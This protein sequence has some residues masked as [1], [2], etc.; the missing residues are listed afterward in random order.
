M[1]TCERCHRKFSSYDALL[2]HYKGKH[3]NVTKLTQ[4]ENQVA[5]EKQT[6]V[7]YQSTIR[8]HGPSRVKLVAFVMIVIIAIGVVGYV[9][10]S[11]KEQ[12]GKKYSVGAVA[13]DF[14][15][16]DTAGGTF[17]LSDYRGK[18][19]VL[20]LFN[21]GLSC[22]PCLQQM[23]DMDQLNSQ[24]TAMNVLMVSITGD[25]LQLLGNWV[26]SSGPRYGKVLSDQGL[27]VSRMYDML[28]ADVS[29]MPGT[30]PGHT[31]ILINKV[32]VIVWRADYGPYNMYVPNDQI[33]AQVRKALGS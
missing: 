12:T 8:S 4:L 29:M 17:R 30:A 7:L 5:A 20:L 9:A 11:P 32:G 13:V 1:V 2:Q 15:L 23:K 14:S 10:L 18:S 22:A 28:G 19:N 33:I 26:S 3:S 25:Q 21:E 31:F 6:Q 24:F 16:P 27:E